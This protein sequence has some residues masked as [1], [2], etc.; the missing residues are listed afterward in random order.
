MNMCDF[1]EAHMNHRGT[2][3]FMSEV[4]GGTK[5]L[6]H[7]PQHLTDGG[8]KALRQGVGVRKK[9]CLQLNS[10]GWK[11]DCGIDG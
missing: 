2:Q 10:E 6:S 7:A 3:R 1:E 5:I 11:Q 9:S 4:L 8:T